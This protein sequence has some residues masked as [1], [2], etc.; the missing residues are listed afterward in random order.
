MLRTYSRLRESRFSLVNIVLEFILIFFCLQDE[1]YDDKMREFYQC[2]ARK[3]SAMHHLR[4]DDYNVFTP[5]ETRVIALDDLLVGTLTYL[6][7]QIVHE[8]P[9]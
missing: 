1:F 9:I 7:D 8:A 4:V 3:N 2:F 6:W 5:R